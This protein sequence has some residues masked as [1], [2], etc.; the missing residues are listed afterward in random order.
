MCQTGEPFLMTSIT[1]VWSFKHL[2]FFTGNL[3]I[4]EKQNRLS[5]AV[6]LGWLLLCRSSNGLAHVDPHLG[7]FRGSL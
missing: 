5:R 4:R 2:D 1:H 3:H 6:D 7:N